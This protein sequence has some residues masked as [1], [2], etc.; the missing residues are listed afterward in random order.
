[1]VL[2]ALPQPPPGFLEHSETILKAAGL[3]QS[4][5]PAKPAEFLRRRGDRTAISVEAFLT[6]RTRVSC[7]LQHT[8]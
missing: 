7:K 1:M 4:I 6:V 2:E 3:S 8:V 5:E